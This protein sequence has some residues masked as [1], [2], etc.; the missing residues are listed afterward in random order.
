MHMCSHIWLS[1]RWRLCPLLRVQLFRPDSLSPGQTKMNNR[2]NNRLNKFIAVVF[3]SENFIT[4][5]KYIYLIYFPL[6]RE[7]Y[8][9]F[10]AFVYDSFTLLISIN[11]YLFIFPSYFFDFT[12]F[13]YIRNTFSYLSPSWR[14]ILPFR[15]GGGV[16][17]CCISGPV[18]DWIRI[19]S[20]R[21]DRKMYGY[22][23]FFHTCRYIFL[24]KKYFTWSLC[25][26]DVLFSLLLQI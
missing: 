15:W 13:L 10:I 1:L 9:Y 18:L 16:E 25:F 20:L 7:P 24:H 21:T 4:Q 19:R 11:V 12:S 26:I 6:S 23:Q 3:R 14:L 5:K 2:N 17:Q 8:I 22:H